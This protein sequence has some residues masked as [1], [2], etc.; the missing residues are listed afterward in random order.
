MSA[1][2]P[3]W[4]S[5]E[6]SERIETTHSL[7]LWVTPVS[8]LAGV[9]RH[10]LDVARAGIPGWRLEVAAPEGPLLEQLRGM[11]VTVHPLPL[12]GN[13]AKAVRDLRTL[14]QELKPQIVHSHLAKADLL[15]AAAGESLPLKRISSEHG[16]AA[17]AR[18]YNKNAAVAAVKQQ[19]HRIRCNRFDHLIAVS[20][21]TKEQMLKAWSPK[22]PITVVLNGVDRPD[23]VERQAGKRYLSLSRLSHEKNIAAIVEAFAELDAEATLTIAG[24]GPDKAEIEEQIRQLGLTERVTLPGFVNADEALAS[25][26]VLVQLSKWEN[27]SYSLLDAVVHRLGVV[28]TPVGGNPEIL[29]ER[30]LVEA[31]NT[32]E[33]A[34]LM[35]EQ[36]ELDV[37]PALPE[38]WPTVAEMTKQIAAIYDEVWR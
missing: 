14:I 20:A 24:D 9:A 25:H 13:P 38:D 12:D 18:L 19:L 3:S 37:R 16:I 27:A 23:G 1:G 26:D 17:D 6:R 30:C 36:A 5:S 21:S 10:V 29:P 11:G 4:L 34:R 15:L 28:A 2:D 7:T 35:R 31:E 33:V 32:Y 8:N 22:T